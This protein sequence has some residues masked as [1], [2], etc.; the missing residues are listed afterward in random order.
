MDVALLSVLILVL[1]AA[2]I[3]LWSSSQ[4]TTSR[5]SGRV[6][7]TRTADS[8]ISRRL[9]PYKSVSI[10]CDSGA[11]EAAKALRDQR[12]LASEPPL[13]PLPDCSSC[14]CSCKYAHHDDRRN[15]SEDRRAPMALSSELFER[16][17]RK[18]RRNQGGRRDSDWGFA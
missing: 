2:F 10:V 4:T 8:A 18:D 13:F 14:T 15:K 7:Y 16:P 17:G 1:M 3:W 12:I 9:L 6:S 11:C 5:K